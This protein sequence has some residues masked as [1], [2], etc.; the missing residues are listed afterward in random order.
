MKS[1]G[2]LQLNRD[3][4]TDVQST[5]DLPVAKKG[6]CNTGTPIEIQ[7]GLVSAFTSPFQAD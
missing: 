1:S 3:E 7:M 2:S 5:K 6:A 4:D